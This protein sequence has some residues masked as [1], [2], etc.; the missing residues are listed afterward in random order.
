MQSITV[1][2]VI[3]YITKGKIDLSVTGETDWQPI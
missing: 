1:L 3:C 2:E